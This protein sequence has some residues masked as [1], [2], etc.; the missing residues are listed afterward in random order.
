MYKD[1]SVDVYR[2]QIW[3]AFIDSHMWLAGMVN[4]NPKQ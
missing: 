1:R 2:L 4:G 3:L